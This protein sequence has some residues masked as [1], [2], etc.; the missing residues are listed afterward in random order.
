MLRAAV[1]AAATFLCSCV[2]AP[3]RR[4]VAEEYYNLGNAQFAAGR[5]S[6]ALSLFELAIKADPSLLQ[7]HYNLSLAL[8]RLGRGEEAVRSLDGLLARD[9]DNMMVVSLKGFAAYQMGRMDEALSLYEQVLARSPGDRDA[10]YNKGLVLARLGRPQEAVAALQSV[11][12][13]SPPDD[14]ALEALLRIGRVHREGGA[15]DRVAGALERYVEWK[16]E[17]A[18]VLLDLAAAYRQQK[19]HQAAMDVY[20]RVTALAPEKVEAWIAQAELLLTVLEDPDSGLATLE[21]ALR[22]GFQ[23]KSR[24]AALLADERLQDRDRVRLVI[25]RWGMLEEPKGG[26][27]VGEAPGPQPNKP[28]KP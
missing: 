7:A 13:W 19:K 11:A 12:D 6:R 14:L 22:G 23:D 10:L 2:S 21:R 16:P 8:L 27:A 28:G 20:R 1:I 15:W 5:F 24:L 18:A 17:D 26:G 25:S 9:P 3:E 4:A